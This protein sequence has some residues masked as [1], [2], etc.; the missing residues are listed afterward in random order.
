M[1]DNKQLIIVSFGV[2]MIMGLLYSLTSNPFTTVFGGGLIFS[3]LMALYLRIAPPQQ[4][5]TS[6]ER[7]EALSHKA[8]S[9]SWF[10]SLS[11]L[12]VLFWLHFFDI[13]HTTPEQTLV[14]VWCIMLV[15]GVGFVLPPRL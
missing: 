12:P 10:C 7:S 6:D 13:L 1:E 14:I 3:I 11:L 9:F 15:S 8:L 4:T 5:I 2:T